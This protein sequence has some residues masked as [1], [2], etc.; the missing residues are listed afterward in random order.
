[1]I[2]GLAEERVG[3]EQLAEVAVRIFADG[4]VS[5]TVCTAR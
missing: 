4:T 2:C 5:C 1:M 3:A